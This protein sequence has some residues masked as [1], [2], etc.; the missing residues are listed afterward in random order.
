MQEDLVTFKKPAVVLIFGHS[1]QDSFGFP[2][3]GG[4]IFPAPE[5]GVDPSRHRRGHIIKNSLRQEPVIKAAEVFF[6][7]MVIYTFA[8]PGCSEQEAGP[9]ICTFCAWA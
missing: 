3:L 7:T 5:E 4:F 9:I 6:L 2:E 1:K 8:I